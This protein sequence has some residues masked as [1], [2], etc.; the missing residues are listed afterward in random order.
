MRDPDPQRYDMMN[1]NG[2]GYGMMDSGWMGAF[3]ALVVVLL[4]LVMIAVLVNVFL[5]LRARSEPPIT[6]GPQARLI[7]D[8]RLAR[9]EVGPEDYQALRVLLD[10]SAATAP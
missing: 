7:L 3:A 5:H 2:T 9:G 4:L 6:G 8:G 10:D 1:D